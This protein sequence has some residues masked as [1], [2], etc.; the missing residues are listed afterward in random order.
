MTG[1]KGMAEPLADLGV[2]HVDLPVGDGLGSCA[3]GP[4]WG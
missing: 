3:P 2:D 1:Q 4:V